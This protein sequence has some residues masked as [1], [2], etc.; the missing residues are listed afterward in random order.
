MWPVLLTSEVLARLRAFELYDVGRS[1]E[2]S[3]P[4][5]TSQKYV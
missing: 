1:D 2:S 4:E 5:L 3:S